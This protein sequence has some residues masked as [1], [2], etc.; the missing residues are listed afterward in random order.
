[1]T[2][3]ITDSEVE[4]STFP[5]MSTLLIDATNVILLMIT[6]IPFLSEFSVRTAD[7]LDPFTFCLISRGSFAAN[8]NLFP[9]V[10]HTSV[11]EFPVVQVQVTVSPGHTDL[12]SHVTEV[13]STKFVN[14]VHDNKI[15]G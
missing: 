4:R 13:S 9:L 11:F 10:V 6:L 12:L 7:V 8:I 2:G 3:T 5:H 15:T 14:I 1:M